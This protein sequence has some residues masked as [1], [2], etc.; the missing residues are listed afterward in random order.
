M[1][2]TQ[3]ADLIHIV[4]LSPREVR[5]LDRE[6]RHLFIGLVARVQRLKETGGPLLSLRSRFDRN[7]RPISQ[8][9]S[10][11]GRYTGRPFGGYDVSSLMEP[12]T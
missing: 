11:W 3:T 10:G 6:T 12:R 4:G 5:S 1:P 8:R 7:G 9:D 2:Q